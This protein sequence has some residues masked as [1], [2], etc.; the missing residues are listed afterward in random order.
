[1]LG[2]GDIPPNTDLLNLVYD[3]SLLVKLF[4]A[5]LKLSFPKEKAE[6][7]KLEEIK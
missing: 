6:S 3:D 2:D 7:V 4:I 1:M 5:K